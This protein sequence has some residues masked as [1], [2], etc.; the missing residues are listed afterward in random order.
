MVPDPSKSVTTCWVCFQCFHASGQSCGTSRLISADWTFILTDGLLLYGPDVPGKGAF[1]KFVTHQVLASVQQGNQ[2]INTYSALPVT[3][4]LHLIAAM[5]Q[6]LKL[7]AKCLF[8]VAKSTN[9]TLDENRKCT[10]GKLLND[11]IQCAN[12]LVWHGHYI[13][14]I[15]FYLFQINYSFSKNLAFLL[16]K[17]SFTLQDVSVK[18]EF[19]VPVWVYLYLYSKEHCKSVTRKNLFN[20]ENKH[21]FNIHRYKNEKT[22]CHCYKS[23][24]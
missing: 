11:I 21:T 4:L 1:Q 13:N 9:C 2:D 22:A 6:C 3:L 15:Y 17:Y 14:S 19:E 20:E 24:Q 5:F 16:I 18:P 7:T 12:D 23:Y 8:Q 10:L